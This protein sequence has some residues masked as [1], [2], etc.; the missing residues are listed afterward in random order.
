MDIKSELCASASP[1]E[2]FP[3]NS[4]VS[5]VVKKIILMSLLLL[6]LSPLS[7]QTAQ[8]IEDLLNQSALTWADAAAF[9]LEASE[10]GVFNNANAFSFALEQNWL[11]QNSRAEEQARLNGIALLLMQSFNRKGGFMYW[12]FTNPR[13]AFRELQFLDIIQSRSDPHNAVSGEEL[14][15]MVSRLLT[16]SEA[17]EEQ[18]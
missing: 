14:L 12:L 4:S 13:Y 11:P 15:Y 8:K 9:V 6:I 18:Q 1:R 17:E 5:S 2:K 7:A 10:Q 3:A 16:M